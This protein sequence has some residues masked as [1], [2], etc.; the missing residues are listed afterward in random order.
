MSYLLMGTVTPL[1]SHSYLVKTQYRLR[2]PFELLFN[3][4]TQTTPL[5][6]PGLFFVFLGFCWWWFL[7]VRG[8]ISLFVVCCCFVAIV[9]GY[10]P[11]RRVQFDCSRYLISM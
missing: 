9:L 10:P 7:C 8:V 5:Q 11:E 1:E 6:I 3:R 4:V 2:A